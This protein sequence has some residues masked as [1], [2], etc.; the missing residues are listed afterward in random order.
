MKK[1]SH[2]FGR[3]F[4]IRNSLLSDF[5][6][7]IHKSDRVTTSHH[8]RADAFAHIPCANNCYIHFYFS[9]LCFLESKLFF[10]DNHRNAART[11]FLVDDQEL[12]D[13]GAHF[14][15]FLHV[16]F[17]ERTAIFFDASQTFI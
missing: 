11:N 3:G 14:I 17:F 4:H 15:K 8:P 1:P 5:R 13:L 2:P 9:C 12:P 7:R 6:I 16:H 10:Y